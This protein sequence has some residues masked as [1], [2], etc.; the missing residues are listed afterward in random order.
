MRSIAVLGLMGVALGGCGGGHRAVAARPAVIATASCPSQRLER[1]LVSAPLSGESGVYR[2]G[3]VTLSIGE[4]LAQIPPPPTAQPSGTDAIA[5]I[6]GDR[7]VVVRVEPGAHAR[8]AFEFAP[9]PRYPPYPVRWDG[10]PVR[11]P[12]CGRHPHRYI[13]GVTF[14]GSGCVRLEVQTAHEPRTSMLIPIGGSLRDCPIPGP[15][16]R[17][18][19]GSLPFLGVACG[20]P[21][22]I[23]CDRVGV[24]VTTRLPASLIVVQIAGRLVALSPPNPPRSSDIWLGYL[25]NIS[26]RRGPLRIPVPPRARLWF[27]VPEVNPQVRVTAFFPNGYVATTAG[28]VQLHPGFG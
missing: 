2:A 6:T 11:F 21:D 16:A 19:A 22:S 25:Q 26:L 28:R 7:P 4:D 9:V 24:G 14:A 10:P 5:L 1:A 13:G 20:K 3:P 17:L 8:L 12:A 27:G 15:A 23:A 18:P